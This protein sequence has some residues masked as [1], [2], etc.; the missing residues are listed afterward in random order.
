MVQD[1]GGRKEEEKEGGSKEG[2]FKKLRGGF[3][4]LLL[5]E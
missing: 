1:N 4:C 2:H 3:S 5:L